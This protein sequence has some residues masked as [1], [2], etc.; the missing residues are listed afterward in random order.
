VDV[1]VLF[2]RSFLFNGLWLL[3]TLAMTV[4]CFAAT[5]LPI[6]APRAI[7]RLWARVSLLLLRVVCGVRAQVR[8]RESMPE[9]PCIVACK[10]QSAWE[11]LVFLVLLPRAV[12]TPKAELLKVPVFGWCLWRMGHIGIER[13]GGGAALRSLVR[14]ARQRLDHGFQVVI[15][16]EGTRG[17]PGTK[18]QYYP[19]VAALYSQLEATVVPVALNSGLY[20]GRNAFLKKPGTI[21]L[22]F[23]API[24][25]GLERR[26]FLDVLEAKI[27]ERTRELVGQSALARRA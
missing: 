23:L 5:P 24:A 2:L 22:E 8:G 19:G 6:A 3:W 20:W 12:Y 15:F 9:G 1:L 26:E 11:T 17:A 13:G 18:R 10:H 16:P 25:P 7:S 21:V 27:E 14:K 4:M